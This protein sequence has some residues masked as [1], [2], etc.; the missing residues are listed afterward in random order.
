[1]RIKPTEGL[2]SI[3]STVQP[4][5][6]MSEPWPGITAP[7]NPPKKPPPPEPGAETA[8]VIP[9]ARATGMCSLGG[10]TAVAGTGGGVERAGIDA[11]AVGVDHPGAGG[12]GRLR[13][14]HGGDLAVAD[15]E[16][17]VLDGRARQGV[18]GGALEGGDLGGGGERRRQKRRQK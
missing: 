1:M 7:A 15:D 3:S 8:W 18:N 17:A 2:M 6:L 11:Q 5:R 10:C 4:E 9:F 12:H 13:A 14:A 16:R